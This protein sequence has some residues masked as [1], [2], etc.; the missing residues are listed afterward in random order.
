MDIETAVRKLAKKYATGLDAVVLDRIEEMKKDDLSH[1]LLYGALGISREE[2]ENI[3]V[4][5]NKGR[6]LYK[7][8]GAFL[9]DAAKLCINGRYPD[10]KTTRIENPLGT[11]PKTFEIDMLVEDKFGIEIK[12]RDAT[13]DGDHISKEHA[14]LRCVAASGYTPVRVMFYE[15]NRTQA[16]KIQAKLEAL[17]REEGGEIY[18]GKRAWEWIHSFTG[19]DLHG[20]LQRMDEEVE[21]GKNA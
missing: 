19:T 10:A 14:R 18:S 20:I 17:Y 11:R 2:G 6:F 1:Y 13:T 8:A 4:Y 15:P 9:E 21:A 5:Q 16:K 7:Y 12:W 3:D